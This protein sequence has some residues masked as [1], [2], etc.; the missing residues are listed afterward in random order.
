[1]NDC[2][3]ETLNGVQFP[4]VGSKTVSVPFVM[5]TATGEPCV[6]QPKL[7]P[8]WTVIVS[9]TIAP[10]FTGRVNGVLIVPTA[11]ACAKIG[12]FAAIAAAAATSAATAAATTSVSFMAEPPSSRV[13]H[14]PTGATLGGDLFARA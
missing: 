11:R 14:R 13:V 10:G 12:G 8:G 3:F 1:M 4:T 5:M 2:P 7:P 6:C 9:R